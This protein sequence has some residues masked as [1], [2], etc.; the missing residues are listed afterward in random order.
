MKKV[1]AEIDAMN[2]DF[3]YDKITKHMEFGEACFMESLRLHPR[4]VWIFFFFYLCLCVV[5]YYM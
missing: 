3:S 4:F 2:G 1:V 5:L